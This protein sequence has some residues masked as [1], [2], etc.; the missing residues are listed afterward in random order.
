MPL[1]SPGEGVISLEECNNVEKQLLCF[2]T[3]WACEIK[4]A[5][6]FSWEHRSLIRIEAEK[7]SEFSPEWRADYFMYTCLDKTSGLPRNR[8]LK[9][10]SDTEVYGDAI[11]FQMYK[12]QYRHLGRDFIL[13][14]EDEE[15][16]RVVL[17]A[18][19]SQKNILTS[20]NS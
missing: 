2:P 14:A 16:P 8:Y 9:E 12:G 17:Q 4:D 20:Q 5:Q 1:A 11:V 3:V 7:L 6:R 10:I 13:A 18:I 15:Y 19:L